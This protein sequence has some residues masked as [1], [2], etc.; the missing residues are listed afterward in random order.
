MPKFDDARISLGNADAMHFIFRIF[1]FWTGKTFNGDGTVENIVSRESGL[2]ADDATGTFFMGDGYVDEN[3]SWIVEYSADSP[4]GFTMDE[5]REVTPG[6][7]LGRSYLVPVNA[8]DQPFLEFIL[9]NTGEQYVGGIHHRQM[10]ISMNQIIGRRET[11]LR[12][13]TGHDP[14]MSAV[15]NMQHNAIVLHCIACS[16]SMIYSSLPSCSYS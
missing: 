14:S 15:A 11:S 2:D 7:L 16:C 9:V 8:G 10:V 1:P 3:Q 13:D 6:F 5:I 4:F 12:T